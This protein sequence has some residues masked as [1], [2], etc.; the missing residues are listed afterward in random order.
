MLGMIEELKVQTIFKGLT[1][2]EI[3][4]F[5]PSISL[6]RFKKGDYVFKEN[7]P[8]KGIYMIKSGR[9]EITKMTPDG[10]KQTL[11]ILERGDF[12]GEIAFLEDTKHASNALTVEPSELFLIPKDF[13][14]E[15]EKREP[16]IAL[17]VIKNIA[18]TAGLKL[19]RMNERFIKVL[20]NY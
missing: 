11:V 2:P 18:I 17:K 13:L 20:V 12:M 15:I 1:D 10:W 8:C 14:K 4:K 9:V 5:I 19:R 6:L 3:D 7:E 16:F